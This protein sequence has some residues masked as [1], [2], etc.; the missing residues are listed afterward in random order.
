MNVHGSQNAKSLGG[1]TRK[2]TLISSFKTHLSGAIYPIFYPPETSRL[3]RLIVD[4][5]ACVC[6]YVLESN[7]TTPPLLPGLN[8][9]LRGA[10]PFSI[11]YPWQHILPWRAVCLRWLC[12]PSHSSLFPFP[13]HYSQGHR[14]PHFFSSAYSL[15]IPCYS[16]HLTLIR[17][18]KYARF[19]LHLYCWPFATVINPNINS[20]YTAL[21][22]SLHTLTTWPPTA[23]VYL[24][25]WTG[26]FISVCDVCFNP[27]SCAK[28]IKPSSKIS[29]VDALSIQKV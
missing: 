18:F 15:H 29:F 16:K 28:A 22:K 8:I 10:L 7:S 24:L 1:T 25:S 9:V 21:I 14:L 5:F 11:W 2:Q 20:T 6:I 3:D 12:S 4:P 13:L 23:Q 26:P 17:S 27:L 19:A